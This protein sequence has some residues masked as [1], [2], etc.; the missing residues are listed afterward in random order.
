LTFAAGVL[1]AL[2]EPLGQGIMQRAFAEVVLL[3]I[4]GGALGCW[5]VLY[6]LSYSTESLAHGMFPGLVVAGIAGVPLLLGGL[7]GVLVAAVAIALARRAPE[8]G[9]DT[10]VAIVVT[11]LFG[12]GVLLALSPSAPPG[13][14]NLLFGDVLGVGDLDLTL[15]AVLAV[16]VVCS[17]R[18]LHGRLLV[19]GFD[20]GS[21]RAF[22]A[23]PRVADTV[24][25]ILVAVAI[26]VGIQGLG[27]L[28][29]VAV[30][31]APAAAARV[32]T[33]RMAP[34][35]ATAVGVAMVAGVA[36]LYLSYYSGTAT[37]ASIAVAMVAAYLC[38]A[39]GARVYS[40]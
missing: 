27:N 12:L 18:V 1:H 33:T 14:Q 3:G 15:A 38:A 13:V 8:I 16:V 31:V 24:L 22:G 20:R 36:G 29:V 21:A 25:L 34:M 4:A 17:L 26:L 28:L 23:D 35:L 30:F 6:G 40:G 32:L 2:T 19:V 5:I 37:G 39:A 7:A 11:S 10:A 9:G